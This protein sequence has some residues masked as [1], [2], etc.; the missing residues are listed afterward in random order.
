[1]LHRFTLFCATALAIF[2]ISIAPSSFGAPATPAPKAAPTAA[3]PAA[4]VGGKQVVDQTAQ[5]LVFG[6]HRF[7]QKVKRPDTEIT[8]QD[9]EKQMQ[10]LKDKGI[11]VIAMQDFLAWRRSEKSI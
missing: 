9:F 5:V 8:P 11:T 6:W 10:E 7:V 3:A 4:K 2:V 1:M